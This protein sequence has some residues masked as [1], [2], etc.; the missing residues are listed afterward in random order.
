[1]SE[2]A[3]S[4]RHAPRRRTSQALL[5]L[6]HPGRGERY[7]LYPASP[8]RGGRLATG[9]D[10]VAAIADGATLLLVDGGAGVDWP[11]AS[12]GLEAA[13]RRRGRR[14]SV[15]HTMA[16]LRVPEAIAERISASLGGDDPVFGKRFEG[17]LD[18][19][20]E[21]ERLREL[22]ARPEDADVAVVFGPGA[23]LAADR[24]PLVYLEVPRNEQQFRARAGALTH[25]GESQPATDAKAAYKRLYFVEWP[26]LSSHKAAVWPRIDRFVDVQ[27]E[28]CVSVAGAALRESLSAMAC[29]PFRARPWFEPGAWGGHWLERHIPDLPRDVPNH[30][31]SFELI[32]PENGLLLEG[33]TLLLETG[34][35]SLMIHAA[36]RVLGE[37][38]ARFGREFPIRFDYL[39]TVQGG[40]LSVQ[41]HPRPDYIRDHFGESFTQDETYYIFDAEPD[42]QVYLGL[43]DG[44]TEAAWRKALTASRDEGAPIDVPRW[45]RTFPARRGDLFLIPSGTVHAAGAGTLVLEISATP[46][47][48]T[49]KLYDWLRLD[50]DGAPR[51]L[52]VERGLANLVFERQGRCV[53][54]EL[55]SRPRS[56]AS[57][58]GWR[59]EH[60]PTHAE[61]FYDVERLFV[62]RA[63]ELDTRGSPQ[64]MSLVRGRRV[65][66]E[67]QGGP[68]LVAR[69]AE[70]FVVPAAA[71]HFTIVNEVDK[72]ATLVRAFLKPVAS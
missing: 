28:E 32:S 48:Y 6:R 37:G 50:L 42:A 1:V 35:D 72:P 4:G 3:A 68:P 57:G 47:I 34:F 13:L 60:L 53:E 64:V 2:P 10:A 45:V 40:N 16:A 43:Q 39:D 5:P 69:F 15:R 49:F 65:Q 67:S 46:Y 70:T 20:L 30:A 18:E 38:A 22:A 24:G 27:R 41:V 63:V 52:N 71:G 59:R 29:A 31:W 11:A 58:D 54:R 66:V 33:D 56:V 9:W 44:L 19:L 61:H 12:A 21:L 17:A 25:L 8:V 62:G 55:I 51:P 7:D 14:V 36:E 23:A 26:L